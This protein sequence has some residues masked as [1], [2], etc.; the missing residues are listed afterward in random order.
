MRSRSRVTTLSRNLLFGWDRST[1]I[2]DANP[3]GLRR[4]LIT[5]KRNPRPA[6]VQ[7]WVGGLGGAH[8]VT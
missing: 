2:D 5:F 6:K 1:K 4:T 7:M 3:S 8:D